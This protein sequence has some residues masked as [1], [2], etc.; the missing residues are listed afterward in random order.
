[1]VSH[2]YFCPY[3]LAQDG[4][5]YQVMENLEFRNDG[6]DL[7]DSRDEE[8]WERVSQRENLP[9]KGETSVT[10]FVASKMVPACF[11]F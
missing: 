7:G 9:E 5:R 6:T 3:V 10:Y 11:R 4:L 8:I 1:M 2:C